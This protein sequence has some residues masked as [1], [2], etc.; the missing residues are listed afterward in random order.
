MSGVG[1]ALALI[2]SPRGAGSTS[3]VLAAG[4]LAV[5]TRHGV[6]CDRLLVHRALA[7]DE[8]WTALTDEVAAADLVVLATPL[9][10]DS[11]PGPLTRALERLADQKPWGERRPG[12][13]LL[14]NCGYPE[15]IHNQTAVAIARLFASEAGLEWRGAL[16]LGGGEA[17]GGRD[18]ETLG[19]R[20]E[21]LRRAL[22][23]AGAALAAGS[24]VPA[25]AV[26][27]MARSLLPPWIYRMVAGVSMRRRA[28][29]HGV[30]R[31]LGARPLA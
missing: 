29:R 14:I 1:R 11:L 31:Q 3:A 28:R 12:L 23:L 16:A 18:L 30:G 10:V 6:T 22:E 13:V 21:P 4:L 2:G 7:D 19:R 24:E 20:T 27:L 5:L 25:E 15:V 9:Y 8:R 26:R 17:V